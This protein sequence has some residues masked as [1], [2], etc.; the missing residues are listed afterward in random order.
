MKL[1]SDF[2]DLVIPE[3]PG[4]LLAVADGALH[5]AAITFCEQSLGSVVTTLRI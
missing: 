4:C 3:L 2:Y 5:Q 1:W